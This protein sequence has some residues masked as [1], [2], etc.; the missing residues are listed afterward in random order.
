MPK[1]KGQSF[2]IFTCMYIFAAYLRIHADD[3]GEKKY[4]LY[5]YAL[6]ILIVICNL[7]ISRSGLRDYFMGVHHF[8][9]LVVSLL[10]FTGFKKLKI[11]VRKNINIA[12]SATFGV[13]LTH[14]GNFVKHS[15]LWKNV[16]HVHFFQDSP[17]LIPYS[18]TAV[19]IAYVVCTVIE[20][21]RSKMFR[22]LSRGR[23]S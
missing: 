1:I 23:L 21:L 17:Y 16:L 14:T 19:L 10:L 5:G 8:L 7:F 3:F 15:L 11:G 12:A 6:M 13:Y 18:I 22:T 9:A 4:I 20:L 2:I